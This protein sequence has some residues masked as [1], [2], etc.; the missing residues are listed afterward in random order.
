GSNWTQLERTWN[1]AYEAINYCNDF[2]ENMAD[3]PL[4]SFDVAAEGPSNM[5]HMY[6]E[7]KVIRAMLYLDLVRNWGDVVYRKESTKVGMDFYHEGVTD[8]T[9]ILSDLINDLKPVEKMLKYATETDEGVER[10]SR[11]YCQA[12]IGQIALWRGGWSLRPGAG[13]GEMKREADYLDYYA[14]AREYLGK[15][16]SESKHTLTRESFE[17]MWTG[18]CNWTVL[19]NGD[20]IFEIPML[21]DS[22]GSLGYRV[23]VTIGQNSDYPTHNFGKCSNSVNFCGLYPFTFDMRDLRFDAT[24]SPIKYDEDLN[25][26]VDMGSSHVAGWGVA[27]WNKLK[28]GTVLSGSEGNTG[29]NAIRMRYA[30]VLLMY[31]EAVNEIS[32]PIDEA[33]SAL[34]EVRRRAFAP[35]DQAEM[36]E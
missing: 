10:V 21:K 25:Q 16:I 3:S 19:N 24:C 20:V 9:E 1:A 17:Q 34:K 18:E 35:A 5:Q 26:A 30:D 32:G 7:A 14:I 13:T 31:A 33:K 36:V 15:V 28:M 29:I 4:F 8:R 22:S 6:A 2:L 11:E 27:K 23:G 12:L